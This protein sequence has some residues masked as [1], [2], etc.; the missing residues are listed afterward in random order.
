M[1]GTCLQAS[2][3][4][5]TD[6]FGYTCLIYGLSLIPPLLMLAA[7]ALQSA[8]P[9][10]FL[11]KD[12][13]AVAELTK[14][15]CCSVYYGILSNVGI[16]LWCSTAA[17]TL[18]ACALALSTRTV[19]SDIAFF[20]A[21]GLFTGW[22]MLDDFFLV[23]E[24]VFPA[25]GISQAVTYGIYA[26]LALVYFF[27]SLLSSVVIR[28]RLLFVA[29]FFLGL[30]TSLD[31]V[32]HS[33]SRTHILLEDGAK[34]LGIAAWTGFHIETAFLFIAGKLHNISVNRFDFVGSFAPSRPHAGSVPLGGQPT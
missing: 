31:V 11:T 14:G 6:R 17:I 23:H 8:V 10:A 26:S 12:P 33:E 3:N 30:S 32:L 2:V 16:L 34:I 28:P 4:F 21:A 29:L 13:L 25:F 9:V 24:D 19:R 1:R 5:E 18:F 20:A 7:I 27:A 22:L 15:D